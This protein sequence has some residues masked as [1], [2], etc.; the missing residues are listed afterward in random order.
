MEVDSSPT[1]REEAHEVA[2]EPERFSLGISNALFIYRL[3]NGLLLFTLP[4]IVGV[5]FTGTLT[6]PLAQVWTVYNLASHLFTML[7]SVVATKH[8]KR[9]LLRVCVVFHAVWAI[10][11]FSLAIYIGVI[12]AKA[13]DA[14]N[15]DRTRF[16]ARIAVPVATLISLLNTL[17]VIS[18]IQL[19]KEPVRPI[20]SVYSSDSA[21]NN[22]YHFATSQAEETELEDLEDGLGSSNLYVSPSTPSGFA[23]RLPLLLQILSVAQCILWP[24]FFLDIILSLVKSESALFVAITVAYHYSM[25]IWVIGSTVVSFGFRNKPRIFVASLAGFAYLFFCIGLL[26]MKASLMT[27]NDAFGLIEIGIHLFMLVPWCAASYYIGIS[28]FDYS[29]VPVCCG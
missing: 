3:V 9:A 28:Y 11:S 12:G 6:T 2:N 22:T 10:V 25:L 23:R 20:T 21:Y 26:A 19:L 13:D 24:F 7:T 17:G 14:P 15:A 27:F 16:A 5:W 4:M 1:V 18:G 8:H 29:N